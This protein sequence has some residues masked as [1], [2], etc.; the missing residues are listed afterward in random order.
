M[1]YN[2]H[3][4][5]KCAGLFLDKLLSLSIIFPTLKYQVNY[6]E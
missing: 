1:W 3:K 4:L 5:L 6:Y 2:L